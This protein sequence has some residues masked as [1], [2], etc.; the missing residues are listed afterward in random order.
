MIQRIQSIYL[1]LAGLALIVILF[2]PIGYQ[3]QES[4]VTVSIAMSKNILTIALS[5]FTAIITIVTIFQYKSRHFQLKLTPATILLSILN[6]ISI[7]VFQF[8]LG[9]N[10][11]T[12]PNYIPYGFAVFASIFL[13]LAYR[14]IK[15]D[16]E[17]VRSMDRLR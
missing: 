14:G 12:T 3:V 13:F 9:K 11:L 17:L 6:I 10:L 4:G 5:F 8:V 15:A 2:L 7:P 16:E 1:L